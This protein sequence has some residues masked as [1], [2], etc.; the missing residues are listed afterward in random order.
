MDNIMD[1]VA[2]ARAMT[3][4]LNTI[5]QEPEGLGPNDPRIWEDWMHKMTTQEWSD[6]VAALEAVEHVSPGSFKSYHSDN[7]RKARRDI[8]T[9]LA[10][11]RDFIGIPMVRTSGHKD[12]AWR[13]V[14]TMREVVNDYNG[15]NIA[16]NFGRASP[17][18]RQSNPA[19]TFTALFA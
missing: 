2:I 11:S 4:V 6:L 16:N 19:N 8:T 12:T 13:I 1:G 15:V 10:K 18:A 5:A 3:D 9:C 14:M 7:L 17:I